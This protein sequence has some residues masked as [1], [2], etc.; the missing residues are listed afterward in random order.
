MGQQQINGF[1]NM[2]K[3]KKINENWFKFQFLLA[4]LVKYNKN[5]SEHTSKI[6]I[7]KYIELSTL[8]LEWY[9]FCTYVGYRFYI[10]I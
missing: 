10:H 7:W 4:F 9:L 6:L 2:S 1:E 3:Y 8:N 5:T